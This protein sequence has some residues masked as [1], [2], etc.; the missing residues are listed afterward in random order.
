MDLFKAELVNQE[1]ILWRGVGSGKNLSLAAIGYVLFPLFF[2]SVISFAILMKE[3]SRP[4]IILIV[5]FVFI[6]LMSAVFGL[7]RMNA[8]PHEQYCITNFRVMIISNQ[9][10][11]HVRSFIPANGS[12]FPKKNFR[13]FKS[14]K[15]LPKRRAIFFEPHLFVRGQRN[16]MPVFAGINDA[17]SVAGIASSAFNMQ[18]KMT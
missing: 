13:Q 2:S 14:I 7:L 6:S 12:S 3:S 16:I 4:Q 10:G 9:L 15:V 18:T 17:V 5:F 8:P 1:K 11:G